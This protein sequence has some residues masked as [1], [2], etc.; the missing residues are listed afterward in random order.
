MSNWLEMLEGF[1]PDSVPKSVRESLAAFADMA[2]AWSGCEDAAA[3]LWLA[4]HVRTPEQRAEAVRVVGEMVAELNASPSGP[5]SRLGPGASSPAGPVSGW[6]T[7]PIGAAIYDVN[8]LLYQSIDQRGNDAGAY[9]S[10][11]EGQRTRYGELVRAKLRDLAP[12]V[13]RTLQAPH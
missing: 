1:R 4:Y 8:L 13:R 11:P 3:L 2:S 12:R 5:P 10:L 7:D 6:T 9:G